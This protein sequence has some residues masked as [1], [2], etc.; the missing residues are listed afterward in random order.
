MFL[1]WG[2]QV[3]NKSKLL[4]R[5]QYMAVT[6][7]CQP[8]CFLKRLSE[9]PVFIPLWWAK[10]YL[11]RLVV[12]GRGF[13]QQGCKA[14]FS[15]RGMFLGRG[16][17]LVFWEAVKHCC[18]SFKSCFDFLGISWNFKCLLHTY[19]IVSC[20]AVIPQSMK[21]TLTIF[22]LFIFFLCSLLVGLLEDRVYFWS[23]QKESLG[24]S[25]TTNKIN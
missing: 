11:K 6:A 18:F 5:G 1:M 19:C 13:L 15:Q 4:H 9:G 10:E 21:T 3:L 7:S 22:P 14:W 17:L 24:C 2:S 16:V 8:V 25:G 20:C 12:R 23:A